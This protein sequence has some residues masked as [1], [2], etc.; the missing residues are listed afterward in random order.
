MEEIE[1]RAIPN[2]IALETRADGKQY[3]V[4]RAIAFNVWSQPLGGWFQERINRRALD[5]CKMDDVVAKF[6]HD[7]NFTLA[8]TPETLKLEIRDDGLWYEFPYDPADPDHQRVAAK[9]ARGDCRGSSFEFRIRKGGATWT[10]KE[11]DDGYEKRDVMDIEELFDVAP[12]INPAYLQTSAGLTKRSL[13]AIAAER[14][15]FL[16][17]QRQRALA[18]GH[19]STEETAHSEELTR[20]ETPTNETTDTDAITCEQDIM[21]MELDD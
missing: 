12:V 4:G 6:N 20:D 21:A 19:S 16:S 15:E 14:D 2:P 7:P 11:G 8:R 3:F 13:D 9:I 5:N 17:E 1:L 10:M 18:D